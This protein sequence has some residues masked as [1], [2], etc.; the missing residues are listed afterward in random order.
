M[1][2]KKMIMGDATVWVE[3]DDSL[4]VPDD[5]QDDFGGGFEEEVS[6][7]I[8]D[9]FAK[10]KESIRGITGQVQEAF[11]ENAPDQFEVEFSF[12]FGL[13]TKII[14]VLVTNK[15]TAAL[16]VKAQWKKGS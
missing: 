2:V 15:T 3:I 8:E 4:I 14:P 6:N 16:K 12:A 13:D 9:G 7:P 5:G 10:V 11:K 1:A